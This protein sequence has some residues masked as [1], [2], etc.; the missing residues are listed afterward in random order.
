MLEFSQNP[1]SC[2][3]CSC[4][5][6]L[7]LSIHTDNIFFFLTRDQQ[8][9]GKRAR[10]RSCGCDGGGGGGGNGPNAA[11]RG[12]GR[13]RGRSGKNGEKLSAEDLD[14]ELD[15]YHFEATRIK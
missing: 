8:E 15:K 2:L 10:V 14:A 6:S 11:G 12:E 1:V 4:C 5:S 13:G 3:L 7:I 9:V